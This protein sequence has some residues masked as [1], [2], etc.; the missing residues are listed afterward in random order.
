MTIQT[1]APHNTPDVIFVSASKGATQGYLDFHGKR[2]ECALGRSGIIDHKREGD[3]GTPLGTFPLRE[4]RFRSDRL[5]KPQ[6]GLTTIKTAMDDGWCDSPSDPAYNQFVK[7]PY[8]A[9]TETLWRDDQLYDIAIMLGY[10]DA[11]VVEGAGSA[12]FFHLAKTV[13]GALQ[14][15]EGCV[16]LV[17]ADMLSV[18]RNVHHK[19]CM[20]ISLKD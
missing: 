10:N 11:P 6:T 18:L 14:P 17:L 2:Y 5:Q 20:T 15:T 8:P 3:G 4:L 1:P 16:A 13:D 9:S 12:I 19:T 7:R